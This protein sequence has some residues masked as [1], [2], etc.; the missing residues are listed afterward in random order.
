MNIL[1]IDTSTSVEVVAAATENAVSDM[2]RPV[3]VSHSA[4]LFESIDNVLKEINIEPGDLDLIGA[5]IGPG[6]FTGIRIAVTTA[7]MFSQLLDLPLVGIKSQLLYAASAMEEAEKG[8][9]ILVAFDAKK[10]KVF[11][12]LYENK[13]DLEEINEPGDYKIDDLLNNVSTEEETL[14]IGD[15]CAKFEK[16]I[17]AK[18]TKQRYLADYLPKAEAVCSLV[19]REY[20]KNPEIREN[21]NNVVPYYSRLSDAE[22]IRKNK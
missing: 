9:N 11:G 18:I 3:S 13:E 2:I 20:L 16:E 10:G 6:S 21:F 19:K 7:R 14:L 8:N 5:G 17:K 1:I 15:G 22:I 4:T 12:A